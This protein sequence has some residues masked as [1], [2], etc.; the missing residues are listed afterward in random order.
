VDSG[1][2]VFAR[3]F[4]FDHIIR[5][6]VFVLK[7]GKSAMIQLAS[8][9]C[10]GIEATGNSLYGGNGRFLSGQAALLSSESNQAFPLSDAPRPQPRI[11]SI[12]EWQRQHGM[13]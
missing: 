13:K 8:A 5:G 11:P 7:D 12:F 9:D 1:P 2:G 4:S 3:T 10:T 6:N